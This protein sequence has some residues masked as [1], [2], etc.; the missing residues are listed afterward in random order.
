MAGRAIVEYRFT[1]ARARPARWRV[2]YGPPPQQLSPRHPTSPHHPLRSLFF[3]SPADIEP[4]WARYSD[5]GDTPPPPRDLAR[6]PSRTFDHSTC[7]IQ[8]G[9]SAHP[10]NRFHP[11]PISSPRG[12]I[13]EFW[14]Q[15]PTITRSL[16]AHVPPSNPLHI[17]HP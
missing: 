13:F 8:C 2:P 7:P 15:I 17:P 9:P 10:A 1:K 12:L 11:P 6:R 14:G 5:F 3:P 4:T 16:D